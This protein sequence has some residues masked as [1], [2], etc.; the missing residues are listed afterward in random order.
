MNI[1]VYIYIYI[2]IY[3]Y[4]YICIYLIIHTHIHIYICTCTYIHM[5][6]Y[7][8]TYVHAYVYIHTHTHTCIYT[9]ITLCENSPLFGGG[10]REGRGKTERCISQI[11]LFHMHLRVCIHKYTCVREMYWSDVLERCI[12]EI[13]AQE[14]TN[15]T[16]IGHERTSVHFLV[17]PGSLFQLLRLLSTH[18]LV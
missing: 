8:C 16:L 10:S 1:H 15:R 18:I 5:Y 6:I 9:F 13:S 7:T 11:Y 4:I 12:R 3:I 17:L 14:W 2:C